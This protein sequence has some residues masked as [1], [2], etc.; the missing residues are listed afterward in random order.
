MGL[1]LSVKTNSKFP[2]RKSASL[3]SC[4]TSLNNKL[5]S[6]FSKI[7]FVSL[8]GHKSPQIIIFV[9]VFIFFG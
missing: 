4:I 9:S 1:G 7:A 5:G 6:C 2:K 8:V 3:N